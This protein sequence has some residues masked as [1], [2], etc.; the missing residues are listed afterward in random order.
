MSDELIAA[1]VERLQA[2]EGRVEALEGSPEDDP[3]GI[4]RFARE[5]R[6]REKEAST[7]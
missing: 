6:A 2:L 3:D 1:V 4:L 7:P 5:C